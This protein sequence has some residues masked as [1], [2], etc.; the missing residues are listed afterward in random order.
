M[1]GI[2]GIFKTVLAMSLMGGGV[3]ILLLIVKPITAKNFP[4]AG[5]VL[6]GS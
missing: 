3:T 6:H 5:S 2:F 1:H 4:P